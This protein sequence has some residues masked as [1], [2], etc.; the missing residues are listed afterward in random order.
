L[1]IHFPCLWCFGEKLNNLIAGQI[2]LILMADCV[3]GIAGKDFVIIASD[4]AATRSILKIQDE[5]TKLTQLTNNQ[6]LAI[7]GE[8][9][10]RNA[11][12][13]L[14]YGELE[15]YYYRYNNRLTTD[16]VANFT[17]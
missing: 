12:A 14:I 17:R 9:A 1:I 6:I 3:F 5:D 2:I 4:L 11:F 16:E 10:D 13:K 8:N 15:Y 7:S